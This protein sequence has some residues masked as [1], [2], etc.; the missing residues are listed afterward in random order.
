[1]KKYFQVFEQ[2]ASVK[3]IAYENI[4][5]QI[6]QGNLKPGTWLREQELADAMEI[7]RAPIRE[8]FNQ[9]ET[10]GFIEIL[11]RKGAKVIS[12]SEK[13]VENIFEI[14]ENLELLAVRKSLKVISIDHLN[15]IAKKFEQFQCKTT[16]KENRLQYLVLDKEFHDLLIHHCDNGMLI[17][18]LSSIQEKIHWLRGFSLDRDSFVQSIKEHLAIINAI[19]NN[20]KKMVEVNLLSHLERAKDSIIQEI[21]MGHIQ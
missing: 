16:E 7:S 19:Q 1:M 20:N 5:K 14:R 13:E 10:E 18:L 9:L 11:P 17:Q 12:L 3:E 21:R 6:I 4:K 2:P 15:Q 8:A